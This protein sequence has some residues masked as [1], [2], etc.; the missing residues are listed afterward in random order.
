[1]PYQGPQGGAASASD[2]QYLSENMQQFCSNFTTSNNALMAQVQSLQDEMQGTKGEI[3]QL[4]EEHELGKATGNKKM[5]L[6]LQ[7]IIHPMFPDLCNI[8]WSGS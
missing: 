4:K 2:F 3:A 1:M 5:T 8:S 6:F 7:M